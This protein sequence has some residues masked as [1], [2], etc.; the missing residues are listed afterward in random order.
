M[1]REECEKAIL[2]K[3][4]EITKIY[5]SYNDEDG[6]LTMGMYNGLVWANNSYFNEGYDLPVINCA[7]SIEGNDYVSL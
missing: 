6:Y 3:L 7:S 4:K 2:S 1:N 5:K